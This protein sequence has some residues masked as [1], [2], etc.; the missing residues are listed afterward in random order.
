MTDAHSLHEERTWAGSAGSHAGSRGLRPD[1]VVSGR[2]RV[3]AL[4]GAGG[5]GLVYEAEHLGLSLPVALKVLRPEMIDH[6]SIV[7]R[8]R[9][10]ARVTARIGSEHVVRV[11]DEG[12]LETGLPYFVMERL[13][14]LDLQALLRACSPLSLPVAVDYARQACAALADAHAAGIIHCDIKPANL[15]VTP[16]PSGRSRVKLLDFGIARHPDRAASDD[17]D[18][19]LGTDSYAAP[20][21]F[22]ATARPDE[23]TDLWSV[24]VVLF[25]ALTGV[26]PFAEGSSHE[27]RLDLRPLEARGGVPEGL[28]TLVR[29][30]LARDR[31][32]RFQSAAELAR[33]LEPFAVEAR[34]TSLA[35]G[36]AARERRP[37]AWRFSRGLPAPSVASR[38]KRAAAERQAQS[39][40]LKPC[41]TR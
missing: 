3:G 4:L 29:R 17:D 7:D 31:A 24:G 6:R 21:Q 11:L 37:V 23:R 25:E 28:Q 18:E 30:C 12:R 5:M 8:F 9:R 1:L 19:R 33:A 32:A 39:M 10:E 22:V 34:V 16:H 14:G 27:R 38:A 15:F 13:R 20:E 40:R 41:S 2:Y 26:L 35:P 36:R